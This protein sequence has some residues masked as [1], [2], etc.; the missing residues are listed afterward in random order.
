MTKEAIKTTLEEIIT[1]YG[2]SFEYQNHTWL[3]VVQQTNKDYAGIIFQEHWDF[4]SEARTCTTSIICQAR[5]CQMGG[6]PDY[7]DMMRAAQQISNA[8][9]LMQ[10]VNAL[11]LYYTECFGA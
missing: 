10:E 3:P 7:A 4:D 5:I 8:A 11:A 6:N 2:F 1:R 9:N